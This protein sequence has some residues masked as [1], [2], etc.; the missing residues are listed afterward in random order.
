MR[1]LSLAILG[2]YIGI[3]SAFSQTPK[4]T[5]QFKGRKLKIEEIDFVAGYYHQDGNKSAITGGIGTEKLTDITNTIELKMI[6]YDKKQRKNQFKIELGI[7]HYTSASSDKIDPQTISSASMDDTRIYPS[8]SWNRENESRGT[9]FGISASYSR[10]ADYLSYGTSLNFSKTSADKNR[11]LDVSLQAFFDTWKVIYPAE[12]RPPGYGTGSKDDKT[13]VDE[14]PRN[15][16]IASIGVS[17]VINKK[18]QISFLVDPTYQ[19]GLLATKFHRV[20]FSDGSLRTENLPDKRFKLPVGFRGS[21]FLGDHLILR[22][23]YRFYIDNWGLKAHTIEME[24]PVKLSSFISVSPFYRFHTQTAI[25]HFAP[26][27][28]N[29]SNQQYYS[30]DYDM[31]ALDGHFFGMGL[32]LSPKKGIFGVKNWNMFEIR[33]GHYSRSTDLTSDVVSIHLKFK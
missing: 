20:Y 31:S 19:Q 1:I 17:Q 3:L 33:Y 13:P 23:L 14:T 27:L 22:S 11:E 15:T 7:D 8:A 21:Y 30:S 26:Y 10:E 12:L 32:R 29:H 18:L 2:M 5:T 16:F 28:Q 9:S 24:T 25:D 4:D 6:K